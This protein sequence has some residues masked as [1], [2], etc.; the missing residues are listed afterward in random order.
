MEAA[1]AGNAGH[2]FRVSGI[3]LLNMAEIPGSAYIVN[4]LIDCKESSRNAPE[5]KC[6]QSAMYKSII[7]ALEFLAMLIAMLNICSRPSASASPG[8]EC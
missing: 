4:R 6:Q 3:C 5:N 7:F 1:T 8:S 2:G